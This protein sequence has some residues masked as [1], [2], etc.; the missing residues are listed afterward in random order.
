MALSDRFMIPRVCMRRVVR[1]KANEQEHQA[2][3]R[4]RPGEQFHFGCEYK[5]VVVRFD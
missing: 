1:V 3:Q 2:H 5:H 4:Q